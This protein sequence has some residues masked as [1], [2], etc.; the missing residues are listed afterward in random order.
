MSSSAKWADSAAER[1]LSS[2]CDPSREL[3]C[4]VGPTASGKSDLA[5]AL[6]KRL[7]GEIVTCDSVQI[8]RAFDLGSGKP[9]ALERAEVPHHLVDLWDPLEPM[10]V[11]RYVELADAAIANIRTRDRIPI[12]CGGTF[13]WAKALLAGLVQTPQ[14][15]ANLRAEH[16]SLVETQGQT[17]LHARLALIDGETA[18]RLHPS[19]VLRVSRALEVYALTGK[20]LSEWHREHAFSEVRHPHRL[21]AVEWPRTTLDVRIRERVVS[22]LNAGWIEHVRKLYADGY[23]NA[24]AM[25]SVG[26]AEVSAHIRG[27]IAQGELEERIVRRT[28]VFVR[29]QRTWL[30][31]E[32]V[33]SIAPT[34]E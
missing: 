2:G 17:A 12:L 11:A 25:R 33:T 28:R 32:A 13:L 24:R 23:E 1:A 8:Y 10:D 14:A 31:H 18:K 20:R 7:S 3:L 15:D 26:Y 19:D 27:E 34:E 22:W 6:A 5:M 4:V 29:R 21:F 30:G 16:R 9:S